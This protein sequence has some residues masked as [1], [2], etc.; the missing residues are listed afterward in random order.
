MLVFRLLSD[1]GPILLARIV[2]NFDRSAAARMTIAPVLFRPGNPVRI[3]RV[4]VMVVSARSSALRTL[5]AFALIVERSVTLGKRDS[6][7]PGGPSVIM[8]TGVCLEFDIHDSGFHAAVPW[9]FVYCYLVPSV[10]RSRAPNILFPPTAA[11]GHTVP[12][13]CARNETN[14]TRINPKIK[15]RAMLSRS[16]RAYTHRPVERSS[17]H[18]RSRP[19][20]RSL[21]ATD[22]TVRIRCSPCNRSRAW[23]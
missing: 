21:W 16:A 23:R 18:T 6:A 8:A 3:T 7:N 11:V 5:K 4:E 10:Y 13:G 22:G 20:R 19:S 9:Q 15:P 14:R 2:V 17:P 1:F 12:G